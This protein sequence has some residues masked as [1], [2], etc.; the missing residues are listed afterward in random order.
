MKLRILGN[1][2]E[3]LEYGL[4]RSHHW[5]APNY[6]KPCFTD[7][8]Y[9]VPVGDDVHFVKLEDEREPRLVFDR[10]AHGFVGLL[11]GTRTWEQAVAEHRAAYPETSPERLE[12]VYQRLVDLRL[13]IE[14]DLTEPPE[15]FHPDYFERMERQ[16]RFL[17]HFETA[18]A[19]RWDFQRRIR[20]ARILLLGAGGTGSQGLLQL[21][22]AGF[23]HIT[24]VDFDRVEASNLNR[25]L[26]YLDEDIGRIKIE[27]ARERI[28]AFNPHIQ[29]NAIREKLGDLD[30]L[31]EWM[32][33]ADLC[34][35][36]ADV[37]P[38]LLRD[39]VNRACIETQTPV[40]YG[41]IYADHVN[42]GPLVVPGQTGCFRCWNELRKS[43]VP[44]FEEYLQH[45]LQVEAETGASACNVWLYG[46]T[47]PGVGMGMTGIVMDMM[48]FVS[49]YAP[50][51]TVGRQIKV[52]LCTLMSD[53]IEWPRLATC[54]ACGPA[55]GAGVHPA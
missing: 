22:A 26:I 25:Q 53:T 3:Y 24:V 9:D 18:E 51:V 13:V 46:T 48:R 32:A 17:A 15:D 54:L 21:A 27:A 23:G 41:G 38:I 50:A 52:N 36:H 20:D 4:P 55:A 37:P 33:D 12:E 14:G 11:D 19:S 34:M 28:L 45:I 2:A 49:G 39:I 29:L 1:H 43:W 40:M 44:E 30:Q 8:F 16:V 42:I 7:M 10:E 6:R 47:G 31:K 5:Q 35:C